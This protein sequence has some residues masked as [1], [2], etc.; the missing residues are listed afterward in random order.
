MP[1]FAPHWAQG[2]TWKPWIWTHIDADRVFWLDAGAT[3][4]RSFR[5]VRDRIEEDG[6]FLVSQGRL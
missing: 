1:A 4:L 3:V 5:G 6:Y 2:F